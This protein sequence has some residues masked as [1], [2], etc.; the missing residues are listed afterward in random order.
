MELKKVNLPKKIFS[1]D[2]SGKTMKD[3]DTIHGANRSKIEKINRPSKYFF[4]ASRT[5]NSDGGCELLKFYVY[6]DVLS[7]DSQYK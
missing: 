3:E 1:Q 2:S 4:Q 7:R 6:W 5:L